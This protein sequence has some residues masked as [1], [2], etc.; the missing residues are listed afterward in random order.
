MPKS[1]IREILTPQPN[2][3][4]AATYTKNTILISQSIEPK[5]VAALASR[6]GL[7]N[8]V[9]RD[10]ANFDQEFILAQMMHEDPMKFLD[11]PLAAIIGGQ[12]NPQQLFTFSCIAGVG[13]DEFLDR[14]MAFVER[15]T[16]AGTLTE[17]LRVAADELFT[18]GAR[19]SESEDPV[20]RAKYT[21]KI[22]IIAYIDATRLVLLCAD[23]YGLLIIPKL[24]K[25]ID[26]CYT[27]GVSGSIRQDST[28]GA[29]IGSYMI[30]NTCSS[31]YIGVQ[32]GVRTIV[33][34]AFQTVP[35]LRDRTEI[36]KNIHILSI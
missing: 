12:P 36:A 27:N 1:E 3:L 17:E 35:R 14:L 28:Q 25:G 32:R 10:A 11:D 30:F 26:G 23:R 19:N 34:C 16:K 6:N 15:R 9:Q 22:E 31:Y 21:T 18:N 2:E 20:E 8:I 29:G 13:R 4:A 33:G 24:L 5:D 7:S